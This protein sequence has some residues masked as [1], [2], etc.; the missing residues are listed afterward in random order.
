M[1]V[2][3]PIN[4]DAATPPPVRVFLSM[5]EVNRRSRRTPHARRLNGVVV[6][7][8]AM[9]GVGLVARVTAM[10]NHYFSGF[11][12]RGDHEPGRTVMG[13]FVPLLSPEGEAAWNAL[14]TLGRAAV[15]ETLDRERDVFA[16]ILSP[17]VIARARADF[18]Q[19][20]A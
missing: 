15:A 2:T 11:Y 8:I 12:L 4:F 5:L 9:E 17:A 1:P 20:A 10:P 7:A 16:L 14:F 3:E 13:G 6:E 18:R 19:E